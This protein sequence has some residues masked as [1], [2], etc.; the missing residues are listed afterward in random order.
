MEKTHNKFNEHVM[1]TPPDKYWS[2]SFKILLV[3]FDWGLSESIINPLASSPIKLAIH[4][5][6]NEDRDYEWLLDTANNA[7]IVIINLT[8]T[9]ETDIIKG[10]LISKEHVWYVGRTELNTIWTRHIDDPLLKLLVAIEQHQQ[11]GSK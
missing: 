4:V 10:S 9:T 8:D 7:D 3:D 5:Y 1:I 11:R 2:D 6:R